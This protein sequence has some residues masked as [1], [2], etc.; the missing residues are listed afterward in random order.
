MAKPNKCEYSFLPFRAY[1]ADRDS[2]YVT[3]ISAM[4]GNKIVSTDDSTS[5]PYRTF[6]IDQDDGFNR[7]VLNSSVHGR[8]LNKEGKV[9]L[10]TN[11]NLGSGFHFRTL[12]YMY[13]SSAEQFFQYGNIPVVLKDSKVPFKKS[14]YSIHSFHTFRGDKHPDKQKVERFYHRNIHTIIY[15]DNRTFSKYEYSY[16]CNGQITMVSRKG[17]CNVPKVDKAAMT[18]PYT[19]DKTKNDINLIAQDGI[20]LKAN[21]IIHLDATRIIINAPCIEIRGSILLKG[22]LKIL[23]LLDAIVGSFTHIGCGEGSNKPNGSCPTVHYTD[24]Y[25]EWSDNHKS[26]YE[27]IWKANSTCDKSKTPE[28]PPNGNYPEP[29]PNGNFPEPPPNGNYPASLSNRYVVDV[30][31][32]GNENG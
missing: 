26:I 14:S 5:L 28:P 2:I 11:R 31:Y 25:D 10:K 20:Y 16:I 23:G 13:E 30:E 18:T 17:I 32:I 6:Q 12:A 1:P 27:H 8:Y 7:F 3:T 19:P 24:G 4:Y 15:G 9:I 21:D 29:P 22:F